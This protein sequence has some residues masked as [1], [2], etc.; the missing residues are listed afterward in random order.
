MRVVLK[1]F[2][3]VMIICL[4]FVITLFLLFGYSWD[5]CSIHSD[6]RVVFGAKLMTM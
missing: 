1:L 2:L 6:N 3:C 5:F 4:P